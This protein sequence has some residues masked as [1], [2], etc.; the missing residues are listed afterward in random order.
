MKGVL[1]KLSVE[2]PKG[3]VINLPLLLQL[4]HEIKQNS[5]IKKGKDRTEL[6]ELKSL[7][8][9]TEPDTTPNEMQTTA[10]NPIMARNNTLDRFAKEK[11]KSHLKDF[12]T[13]DH[14]R[15]RK[16]LKV[17]AHEEQL[18]YDELQNEEAGEERLVAK[19]EKRLATRLRDLEV[20]IVHDVGNMI[21]LGRECEEEGKSGV[22][23]IGKQ[24]VSRMLSEAERVVNS[25]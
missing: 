19:I 8:V 16:T 21:A 1:L 10:R 24:N 3:R 15:L 25:S 14:R 4:M 13:L 2:R 12:L 22:G 18:I 9:R 17:T 7:Q 6:Q 11:S 20:S 23:P 5:R